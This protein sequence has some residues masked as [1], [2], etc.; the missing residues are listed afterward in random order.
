MNR[1]E[2]R[3]V[4]EKEFDRW[5]D[6]IGVELVRLFDR[7]EAVVLARLTG[8]KARK[9]TRHWD[10]PSDRPLEVKGI[11]DAARWLKEAS[12]AVAPVL[13]RVFSAVY[14]RQARQFDPAA[15]TDLADDDRVR[16]ALEARTGRVAEGVATA[17]E[18]VEAYIAREEA[19]GTAMADIADGVRDLYAARKGVWAKRIAGLS[20]VGAV[21]HAAMLAAMDAGSSAKQWLSSRDDKVRPTHEKADGQVRLLDERFRLGGIPEHPVKS[22]LMLPGDPSPDVPIDEVINCRCSLLFSP[23]RQAKAWD[24]G[25]QVGESLAGSATLARE[26]AGLE[27]K[28]SQVRHVRTRSGA[29]HYGQAIG[30][31]I[32]P[33]APALVGKIGGKHVTEATTDPQVRALI[34]KYESPAPDPATTRVLALKDRS[35]R[36]GAYVV[37]DASSGQVLAVSVHPS[38]RGQRVGDQMVAMAAQVDPQVQQTRGRSARP[39]GSPTNSPRVAPIQ[40]VSPPAS[41]TTSSSSPASTPRANS[42][43]NSASSVRDRTQPGDQPGT[44]GDFNADA[45]RIDRL[46]RAY[47]ADRQ[48]TTALFSR[49]G[50]WT[51]AREKQHQAV[52]DHF[53]NQPGVKAD[54]KLLVLGGLPGSGKTTTINSA[55]GQ[56]A[57]GI[58]LSEYVTVNA[59]EVKAQMVASGMVPDYPG[60]SPDEAAT[61]YHAESFEIAN[62]LM[63]QA[64]AKGLN[65]AYD[66]SLKTSGQV[67]F[68]TSA[69]ARSKRRYESQFVFVDVPLAVA[70]QRAR[71]R[72]LA[73]GRYMPL[74]LIDGMR[75][76]SRSRSSGPSEQFDHVKG[77]ADSWVVFDNAAATPVVLGQGGKRP[78]TAPPARRTPPTP[79]PAAPAAAPP[80]AVPVAAPAAPTVASTMPAPALPAA[81]P[82]VPAGATVYAHP[83]GKVIYVLPD[84]SMATYRPDGKRA[85]SSATP[86]KLAAGYGGWTEVRATGAAA[87]PVDTKI[88]DLAARAAKQPNTYGPSGE[89]VKRS[90]A[91]INGSKVEVELR[92]YDEKVHVTVTDVGG[93]RHEFSDRAS[94]VQHLNGGTAPAPAA[95]PPIVAA[96]KAPL[97]VSAGTPAPAGALP[98]TPMDFN[99]APLADVPKYIADPD[100]VFQ[101]KVDGIRGVLVI[102]PGK[103][104]WFASKKGDRLQSSTAAKTTTPMLAK[105]PA[106]PA[107]SPSYRVEGEIL[108]G[109]FHVFDMVIVGQESTDYETR[110]TMADA[111][112][113][114]VSAQ[115]PQ[116]TALP[117][118]RTA[119]EKQALWDAVL[120]SGAEGVMMKRRDAG[121]QG[122]RRVD[123]T[124]KAKVTATADVVVLERNRDGKDN[125]V[126]GML[127]NGK[128]TEIGTVSTGGK[129]KALGQIQVGDVVE[130]E[131]LWASATSNQLTQPRIVR[132]RPDKT[133]ND[134]TDVTQLRFVDKAVLQLA[135]KALRFRLEFQI[136]GA[137]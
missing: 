46:Q 35:S 28:A 26:L 62:S 20:A 80:P 23:P 99:E 2:L 127:V 43:R 19:A 87:D 58:D 30:S 90:T 48:D 63:R 122:G 135:A 37:W 5:E 72:Y 88:G 85:T 11:V 65:F 110:K 4:A 15:V 74:A 81:L 69:A 1:D 17:L 114:A 39:A 59:D 105:L 73:G 54:A 33:N 108:N 124:L 47:L 116:V 66:T 71:D 42:A 7:Q 118:A 6:A 61:L 103:A 24:L 67:S 97:Q 91:I 56:A 133:A 76:S 123:H 129:D 22:L 109:K 134:A 82:P 79:A 21:N 55:A 31:V 96:P 34:A 10:P 113:Q 53:L 94:A 70:K 60:L 95:P 111:W 8:T 107:G 131:Y 27:A 14:G 132:K 83:Q 100:Y 121:Y 50:R 98:V 9:H 78:R 49:G 117:T 77:S 92:G 130:L 125:A 57:L 36:V 120:T 93:M 84:G 32:V 3:A 128:M 86:A 89:P 12:S 112:V 29:Q 68:A 126:F 102:E 119:A 38:L 136:E 64:G 25:M 137:Y 75:A 106:T 40:S 104:P 101:Q 44:S 41:A 52:I 16:E 18:E 115:L 51:A 13:G 45:A